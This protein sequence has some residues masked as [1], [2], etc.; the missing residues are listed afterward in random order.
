MEIYPSHVYLVNQLLTFGQTSITRISKE[1]QLVSLCMGKKKI[2]AIYNFFQN[3]IYSINYNI[4][5]S[6]CGD[7][8]HAISFLLA[9]KKSQKEASILVNKYARGKQTDLPGQGNSNKS[10]KLESDLTAQWR[11]LFH[12]MEDIFAHESNQLVSVTSTFFCLI[13]FL[14]I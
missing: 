13:L 2:T 4:L 5:Y 11:S 6:F 14:I 8:Y 1:E 12:R 10:S 7:R 3:F 9:L